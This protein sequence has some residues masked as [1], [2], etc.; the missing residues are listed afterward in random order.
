MVL[1]WKVGETLKDH[2]CF[3]ER[4]RIGDQRVSIWVRETF[5]FGPGA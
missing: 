1:L 5:V 3:C 2:G 4:L